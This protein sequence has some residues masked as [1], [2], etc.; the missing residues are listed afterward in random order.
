MRRWYE[1]KT[2]YDG[3]HA[4][5]KIIQITVNM[6][7]IYSFSRKFHVLLMCMIVRLLTTL[8]PWDRHASDFH[9]TITTAT[10]Q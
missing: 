4:L 6:S 10:Q 9:N 1:T 8:Q 2:I 3:A 5:A 7:K